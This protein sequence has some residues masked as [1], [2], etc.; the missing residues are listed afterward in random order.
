V[1]ALATPADRASLVDALDRALGDD[2]VGA[3]DPAVPSALWHRALAG[4]ARGFLARPGKELRARLV[5]VG[6]TLGGGAPDAL[7]ERLALVLEILHAGSLIIDDIEDAADLRRG[8]PALHHQVG[9]PVAINTGSWMYFWALAELGQ[10]HLA[11]DRELAAYHLAVTTLVRAHQGQA[12][13][14]ATRVDELDPVHVA[15]VVD[16]VAR[17]KTGTLCR[18]ATEL[19]ALAAG[20]PPVTRAAVGRFGERAGIALQMLDDLGAIASPARR[21]KA[22]EDLRGA[23]PTWPWAWL[24]ER[25]PFAWT[26]LAGQVRAAQA[27]QLDPDTLADELAELVVPL[28]RT[29]VHALLAATLDELAAA[30]GPSPALDALAADL[31]QM[32]ESYG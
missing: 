30:L 32:E 27:G 14:L 18:F 17:L 7:P 16:A 20:A 26:R 12:L 4:P 19:G 3:L 29:R 31:R 13:D 22:H 9:V 23:R 28:G 15:A 1:K 5:H 24:A 8:A 10:L 11:P 6:W 2:G 21:A 25:A